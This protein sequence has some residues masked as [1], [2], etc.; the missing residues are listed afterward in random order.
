MAGVQFDDTG[1]NYVKL[2]LIQVAAELSEVAG[3]AYVTQ[4]MFLESTDSRTAEA[5]NDTLGSL[6][7]C[8]DL[9]YSYCTK[10]AAYFKSVIDTLDDW[11]YEM[12]VRSYMLGVQNTVSPGYTD[13]INS[14]QTPTQIP[15]P[16]VPPPEAGDEDAYKW[17]QNQGYE[18]QIPNVS[19]Q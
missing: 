6:V 16:S 1:L 19:I 3:G 8:T 11:D 14:A 18:N 9:L 5:M 2:L 15:D 13:M 12:A 10:M 7:E 4:N 17:G